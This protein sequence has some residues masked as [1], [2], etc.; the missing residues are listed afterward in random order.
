MVVG[1]EFLDDVSEMSLA[2]QKT[3]TWGQLMKAHWDSLCGCDFFP[4]E[5]LSLTGTIRDMVFFVTVVKTRAV[6]IVGI[7]TNPDGEWMAQM[8]RNLIDAVD[9][10]LRNVTCL[11]H[12]RDPLFTKALEAILRERGVK[13]A[14][15]PVR[16]RRCWVEK[17]SFLPPVRASTCSQRM[18][19]SSSTKSSLRC[20]LSLIAEAIITMRNGSVAGNIAGYPSS[21]T[22]LSK[23]HSPRIHARITAT[24]FRTLRHPVGW[25][26]PLAPIWGSRRAFASTSSRTSWT[27]SSSP[28]PSARALARRC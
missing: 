18:R 8:E 2:E 6:E 15:I 5:V 10:F 3:H 20:S 4:V 21:Q 27:R 14:K 24:I 9:G 12:D 19:R 17:E 28:R 16:R 25:Q 7:A 11:I 13:C 22:G 26:R 1:H 23:R